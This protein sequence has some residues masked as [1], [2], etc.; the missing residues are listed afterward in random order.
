LSLPS[1]RGKR[2]AGRTLNRRRLLQCLAAALGARAWAARA[3]TGTLPRASIVPGGVARI[4][5]GASETAPRVRLAGQRVLVVR[6]GDEWIAV[7][8]LAL[9]LKPGSKVRLQAEHAGGRHERFEIEV[10]PKA[11]GSQHLKVPPGQVDLSAEDLARYTRERAHLDALLR[12]FTESPPAS[13]AML[14]PTRGRRAAAFGLQR[15]FNDQ[16]RSRH[17]G[18]DIAAPVGTPVVAASAGRVIEIGDY[19]FNGR[20]VV[21]DH[22]QGLLS[23]YAHLKSIEVSPPEIVEA[24]RVIGTVGASGRATGPHLHFS[25]YLNSVA[26]DPT[27]FLLDAAK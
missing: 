9:D 5:L 3:W 25:V 7:V 20:T 10:V 11:Y 2:P 4:R 16:L 15:Y 8:G 21:L 27:L 19:F 13:L 1:R 12:T 22:G 17:S 26:V 24:G 6:E 18:L 23:L 14:Q